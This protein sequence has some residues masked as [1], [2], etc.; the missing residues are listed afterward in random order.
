MSTDTRALLVMHRLPVGAL[1]HKETLAAS[2][3]GVR[4]PAMAD[5]TPSR[6]HVM[7]V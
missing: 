4:A 7:A 1:S 3:D 2:G 6:R 5:A